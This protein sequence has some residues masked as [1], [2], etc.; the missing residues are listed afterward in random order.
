MP[1]PNPGETEAEFVARCMADA[2]MLQEYPEAAQ[3]EAVAHELFRRKEKMMNSALI[4]FNRAPLAT[5]G[6]WIHIVP[7]GE[8][9]N[10]EAGLVQVLDEPAFDAILANIAADR[11]RLGDRWP[12]VYAG[13]EHFIYNDEQ[14]S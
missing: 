5:L 1:K 14:D 7:K 3:R 9:P 8:L 11:A 13:K 10:R 4:I 6:G 2:T 12:G